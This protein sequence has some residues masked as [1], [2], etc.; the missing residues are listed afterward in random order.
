MAPRIIHPRSN[1]EC[2]RLLLT[3]G[4][5]KRSGIG[6]GKHPEKYFHNTRKNNIEG[7]RPFIIIPH[8]FFDELGIKLV[9]KLQNWGFTKKEIEDAL[10]GIKPTYDDSDLEA[11]TEVE[12]A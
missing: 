11:D 10:R 12:G 3:L 1:L 6:R 8:L 9:K 4:F 5:E 7:D 2:A